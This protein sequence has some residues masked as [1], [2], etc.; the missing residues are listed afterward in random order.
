MNQRLDSKRIWPKKKRRIYV[1]SDLKK[2]SAYI[3]DEP[4]VDCSNSGHSR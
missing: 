2:L 3:E 4:L 1:E